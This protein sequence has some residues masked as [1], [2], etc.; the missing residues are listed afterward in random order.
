MA[1]GP[2]TFPAPK[3]SSVKARAAYNLVCSVD[4]VTL[5]SQAA[6]RVR[7]QGCGKAMTY[8]CAC[9]RGQPSNCSAPTCRAETAAPTPAGPD[10]RCP[11]G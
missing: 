4:D 7:A 8:R 1:T 3:F 6:D 10:Q 2:A 9:P 11:A 5:E